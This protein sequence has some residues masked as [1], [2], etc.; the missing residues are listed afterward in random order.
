MAT[1]RAVSVVGLIGIHSSAKVAAVSE[2]RGSMT[3]TLR[4]GVFG[5]REVIVRVCFEDGFSRIETVH[6][7][8]LGMAQRLVGV[9]IAHTGDERRGVFEAR[10]AVAVVVAR[11]PPSR[12]IRRCADSR[13]RTAPQSPVPYMM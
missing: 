1:K 2:S 6:Q 5:S 8:E 10:G 13:P 12:F 7:D 11:Y 9:R 3:T 4:S